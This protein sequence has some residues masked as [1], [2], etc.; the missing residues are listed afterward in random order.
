MVVGNRSWFQGDA[1]A[2][3]EH[4]W[5]KVGVAL[6]DTCPVSEKLGC[7]AAVAGGPGKWSRPAE[8]PGVQCPAS[9]QPLGYMDA[10]RP[11]GLEV[12]L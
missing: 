12:Q 9:Q 1:E 7:G 8:K 5:S 4:G 6:R 2:P 3:L 10:L 11:M